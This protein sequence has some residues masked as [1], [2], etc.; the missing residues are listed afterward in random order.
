MAVF[1]RARGQCPACGRE[2]SVDVAERSVDGRVNKATSLD[3]ICRCGEAFELPTGSD[4]WIGYRD[5][6]GRQR[7]RKIG[8]DRR[9]AQRVL[10]K[11]QTEIVEGKYIERAKSCTTSLGELL[12]AHRI[13]VAPS[14]RP[15]SRRRDQ[16]ICRALERLIGASVRIDRIDARAV[17]SYR[18]ARAGEG[19]APATV[20]RELAHLSA[21]LTWAVSRGA[22]CDRPS[23]TTPQPDNGRTRFL[24]RAEV[25]V[26]ID[27]C[28]ADA[29]RPWLVDLVRGALATGCRR[30]ELLALEW[31]WVDE[32]ASMINLPGHACK[33]KR[34]R[35]VPINPTMA[36]VLKRARTRRDGALVFQVGGHRLGRATVGNRFIRAVEAAGL[37]KP[38]GD[39]QRV[40]F[41]TLRH[42]AASW[43]VQAGVDLH[44]VATILGHAS[45]EVTKRYAHL[46]PAHL[47]NAMAYTS[48]E[49]VEPTAAS[50]RPTGNVVPFSAAARP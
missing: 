14:R 3:T 50:S 48:L 19:R 13:E 7:R 6:S 30:G 31:S 20:N 41:H 36:L 26:L 35:H 32:R 27:A 9:A 22:L 5:P 17:E 21:A 23:I 44:A 43:M 45:L 8:P 28:A 15:A 34:G 38:K 12:C 1:R 40:T 39:P 47:Q 2:R 24:D 18:T 46:A 25:D 33:S 4:W 37:G 10:T 49:P 11:I 29:E 42:T 16:A